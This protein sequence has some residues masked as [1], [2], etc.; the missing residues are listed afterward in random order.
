M[1]AYR[2]RYSPSAGTHRPQEM[3]LQGDELSCSGYESSILTG[4]HLCTTATGLKPA[5]TYRFAVQGQSASGN[6]GPFTADLFVT[7]MPELEEQLH[8]GFLKLI[9]A[10]H[11]NL[12]VRWTPP[13][14]VVDHIVLYEV[15]KS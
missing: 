9:G 14:T 2:L 3:V 13:P 11:D 4:Q 5:T 7:T 10:G 6:W 15:Q 12:R 8:G 1:V